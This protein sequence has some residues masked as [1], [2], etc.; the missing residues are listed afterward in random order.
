MGYGGPPEEGLG[1]LRG[2]GAQIDRVD[3]SDLGKMLRDIAH[4]GALVALHAVGNGSEIGRVG[5]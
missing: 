3:S 5:F 1:V 4:V 2:D